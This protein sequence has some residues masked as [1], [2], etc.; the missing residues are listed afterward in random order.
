MPA[1][2][3]NNRLAN[4]ALAALG[5]HNLARK[6]ATPMIVKRVIAQAD[7]K[8]AADHQ[9]KQ[10]LE[11]A[12]PRT[13]E[14]DAANTPSSSDLGDNGEN[15]VALHSNEPE[16]LCKSQ[17]HIIPPPPKAEGMTKLSRTLQVLINHQNSLEP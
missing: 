10:A 1:L 17:E 12:S 8:A 11:D 3:K 4:A 15:L 9:N 7:N 2:A 13:R 16:S 14:G 6:A 5:G